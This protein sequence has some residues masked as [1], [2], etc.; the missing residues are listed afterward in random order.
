[1]RLVN[2]SLIFVWLLHMTS[3]LVSGLGGFQNLSMSYT[4]GQQITFHAEVEPG[5][6]I[7]TSYLFLESAGEPT[8]VIPIQV[9]PDGAI[10][11]DLDI[12]QHS[13]RPFAVTHYWYQIAYQSGD[14]TISPTM[15]FVYEDN[16]YEW[17]TLADSIFTIHWVKGDI[18]FGQQALN[19]A[20]SGLTSTRGLIPAAIPTPLHI[21]IYP[22]R[23]SLQSALDLIDLSWVAGHSS[24]DLGVILVSVPDDSSSA[25]EMERQ[26]PH[27]LM[28]L[29]LYQAS[30]SAYRSLPAWL[31][32]GLAS[33]AEEY[34]NPEYS[35]VL[36][37]AFE[38]GEMLTMESLCSDF[39]SENGSAFLAYAESHD[40]VRYLVD[41]HGFDFIN[42]LVRQYEKGLGCSQG[43]EAV[44]GKPLA[45]LE[46]EWLR[47]RFQSSQRTG[48]PADSQFLVYLT[49][50]VMVVAIPLVTTAL[51][52]KGG[53]Q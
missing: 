32:E 19:K 29:L 17:Q 18:R 46:K 23:T 45:D 14:D 24:P 36:A 31:V 49:L 1:V 42:Q 35:Q 48:N 3:G 21:Y 28:H 15:S 44:F 7:Q 11:V 30:G 39:P 2:I 26:I 27:E 25:P 50:A 47:Y 40:F 9:N 53:K 10:N 43:V 8:Q 41:A 38:T 16:R 5:E 22:D 13:L 33:Y 34:P 20:R 4:F 12:Q 51:Q 52:L 37:A 6:G